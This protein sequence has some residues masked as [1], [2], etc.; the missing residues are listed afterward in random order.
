[1]DR[2]CCGGG[3]KAILLIV[4]VWIILVGILDVVGDIICFGFNYCESYQAQA[5]L[6]K[7]ILERHF[8]LSKIR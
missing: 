5:N 8:S 1:V 6:F 3:F 7:T 2:Q 4:C